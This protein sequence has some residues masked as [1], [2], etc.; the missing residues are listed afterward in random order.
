MAKVDSYGFPLTR[1]QAEW[2][3]FQ[4][5][6]KLMVAVVT[7]KK[8]SVD[9]GDPKEGGVSYKDVNIYSDGVRMSG[10]MW[11]PAAGT[12]SP[13]PAILLTHGWG[14]T[15]AHLDG[16]YAPNFARAGFKVLSFDYRGHGDSDGVV[17]PD[18]PSDALQKA[19]R[20]QDFGEQEQV[21][22]T[23]KVRVVR[24]TVDMVWQTADIDAAL[25]YLESEPGVD[26]KRIGIWGTSQAGG[27]VIA[28]GAL[29]RDRLAAIV[30]QVPSMGRFGA[31][32]VRESKLEDYSRRVSQGQA[33]AGD[34][35]S[36]IPQGPRNHHLPGLDGVPMVR[37]ILEYDP[38]ATA[39]Q[40]QAPTL[41]LDAEN[42]EL[43]D[44][45]ENGE[46]AYKI[47]SKNVPASVY[48]VVKGISHYQAY[49]G[50]PYDECVKAATDF[51][52]QHLKPSSKL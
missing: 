37:R 39:H 50:K 21:V 1:D 52:V 5:R 27:H 15:R 40:I 17:V 23:A 25:S 13:C 45:H 12:P 35:A 41:V 32:A 42:E 10:T 48:H 28:Q 31:G 33:R 30:S 19:A 26:P 11:T 36:S 46:A 8:A 9:K 24:Q 22:G 34:P 2:K 38:I 6:N 43:M 47:I 20:E 14:G 16:R 3:S 44:R 18:E 49:D 4:D 51:F 29:N 7:R